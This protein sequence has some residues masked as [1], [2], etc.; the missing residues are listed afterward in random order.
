MINSEENG[1][2]EVELCSGERVF[3]QFLGPDSFTGIWW[4]DVETG[5]E[6]NETSLIYAW[7][8]VL[9]Q[10]DSSAGNIKEKA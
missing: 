6:F 9:R 3:W 2:Y 5:R 1:I 10:D 8:I 4:R 7:R